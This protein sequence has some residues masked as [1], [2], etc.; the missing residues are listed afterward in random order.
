LQILFSEN[1]SS[2]IL[3]AKDAVYSWS[4]QTGK[5][6]NTHTVKLE[7]DAVLTPSL[8]NLMDDGR[9]LV[10]SN[11]SIVSVLSLSDGSIDILPVK[12]SSE[13]VK[14]ELSSKERYLAI[15]LAAGWN[16][17]NI[18]I[19]DPDSGE[20][21]DAP[22][23]I[24]QP[25]YWLAFSNDEEYFAWFNGMGRIHSADD[26]KFICNS[27]NVTFSA[28]GNS[29]EYSS[30]TSHVI[31]SLPECSTRKTIELSGEKSV[32][33]ISS[34]FTLAAEALPDG[35][36]NIFD[37]KTGSIRTSLVGFK[38]DSY[39]LVFS[40]DSKYLAVSS[41]QPADKTWLWDLVTGEVVV[42]LNTAGPSFIGNR[43]FT[44]SRNNVH[45]WDIDTRQS[46]AT[47][48]LR[49]NGTRTKSADGLL[50]ADSAWNYQKGIFE[51]NVTDIATNKVIYKFSGHAPGAAIIPELQV[52]FSN[53][54]QRLFTFGPDGSILVWDVSH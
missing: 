54:S 53:D 39:D 29:F 7:N 20:L 50:V 5:L 44:N 34:D 37:V 25:A 43:L 18:R 24:Q 6:E 14:A 51:I 12:Y 36:I 41:Y 33:S 9:M 28:D 30:N 22:G 45:V 48:F 35:S 2:V 26:L 11:D 16:G 23:N 38:A 1:D 19:L 32:F 46:L 17:T 13:V 42:K 21:F 31:A 15:S 27:G 49:L 3:S 52:F 47:V 8:I 10:V 40:P 4:S